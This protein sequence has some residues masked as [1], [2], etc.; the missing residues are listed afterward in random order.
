MKGESYSELRQDIINGGWIA[1]ATGRAK[2]PHTF[3]EK[4]KRKWYQPKSTCPFEDP[5]KSGNDD[6]VLIFQNP[7]NKNDWQVQIIPNKFPVFRPGLCPP[8]LYHGPYKVMEGVGYHEI[9]ITRDHSKSIAQFSLQEA[10]LL[11]KSYQVRYR[12]LIEEECVQYVSIFKNYGKEAGATI[13]HPHSQI[14]A[15]PVMP[16]D[17]IASLQ[18]AKRYFKNHKVCAHCTMIN[19]ERKEKKRIV[20]ENEKFIAICPYTSRAAFNIVVTPKKHNANFEH[21][22]EKDRKFFADALRKTFHKLFKGLNDPSYNYFIH[23]APSKG[24][25]D[26][27]FYHWHC[28]IFPKTTVWAGFEIGTGIEVSTIRPEDAAAF[29]RKQK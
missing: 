13:Y 20:F 4:K 15:L 24:K 8:E 16:S 2:R 27:G 17:V 1:I 25:G 12:Q 29:L 3:G 28:E 18:G 22:E 19:W 14:I 9:V 10:D 7:K 5:Q 23:T 6:P 21:M 11:V 26:Y